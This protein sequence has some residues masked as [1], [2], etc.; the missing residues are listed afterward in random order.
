MDLTI[1]TL[2]ED[3]NVALKAA[4]VDDLV[5]G[6]N[7]LVE[8]IPGSGN[9][10]ALVEVAKEAQATLAARKMAAA[11]ASP[12][13]ELPSPTD[14]VR[15]TILSDFVNSDAYADFEA[16]GFRGDSV[17]YEVKD[18]YESAGDTSTLFDGTGGALV[19]AMNR[20]F[21][22]DPDRVRYLLDL[23]PHIPTVDGQID[24][25]KEVI[26]D[27][28]A[29]IAE[30]NSGDTD[31]AKLPESSFTY[32]EVNTG[33]RWV[34]SY[35]PVSVKMLRNNPGLVSRLEARLAVKLLEK[36]EDKILNG[37][38]ANDDP[39]GILGTTG[40]NAVT[41]TDTQSVVEAIAAG[42]AANA[43]DNYTSTWAVVSPA[44]ALKLSTTK[45]S[46]GNFQGLNLGIR[47][48]S[49][50]AIDDNTVLVGSPESGA[51]LYTRGGLEVFMTDKP[52]DIQLRNA[53]FIVARTEMELAVLTPAGFCKVTITAC[54]GY[55][56]GS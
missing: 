29:F 34:G 3:L 43:E 22:V 33:L 30:R 10:S 17:H 20:G 40:I 55:V 14:A 35:V 48:L 1:L 25:Y 8:S 32:S 16:K 12:A 5:T 19:T 46:N 45:D 56:S 2:G 37:T 50:N 41:G 44:T 26:T 51:E 9:A 49:S 52:E 23:I 24:Y 31:F 13:P 4:S 28:T 15:K 39:T 18:L 47:I 36:M 27:G 54:Q 38:G 42:I 53:T 7:G 11:V 21:A 6:I